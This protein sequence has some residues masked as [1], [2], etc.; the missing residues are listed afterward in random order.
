MD[1]LSV[2]PLLLCSMLLVVLLAVRTCSVVRGE[3]CRLGGARG[4]RPGTARLGPLFV[5]V[6]AGL[7][8][9]SCR[10]L[11]GSRVQP[12]AASLSC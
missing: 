6:L 2:W 11:S 7:A 5:V 9:V 10:L 8:A 4:S 3:E 1:L 12:L